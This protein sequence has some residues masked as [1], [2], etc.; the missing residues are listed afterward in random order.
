MQQS[1][2]IFLHKTVQTFLLGSLQF[3][4]LLRTTEV[5][6]VPIAENFTFFLQLFE[7]IW[8]T[9]ANPGQTLRKIW[10]CFCTLP[11]KIWLSITKVMNDFTGSGNP[12]TQSCLSRDWPPCC[13][14]FIVIN[15]NSFKILTS[16]LLL[17]FVI[18]FMIVLHNVNTNCQHKY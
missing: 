10:G 2:Y 7:V 9:T 17:Y 5:C 11:H 15:W 8:E 1:P 18:Q 16:I 4:R 3:S 13:H 12:W 14:K 6:T